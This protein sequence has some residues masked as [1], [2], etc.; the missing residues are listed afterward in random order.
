MLVFTWLAFFALSYGFVKVPKFFVVWL[1]ILVTIIA[2]IGS[3]LQSHKLGH[4]A[5][6]ASG[7]IDYPIYTNAPYRLATVLA[8][9]LVAYIWT[10]FPYPIT[11]RSLLGEKLG[12]L[13]FL[14]A[15]YHDCGHSIA[16]LKMRGKEGDMALKTSPG[17]KLQKVQH[18][19][20]HE[21]M[22]L[23]P[24]LRMH[25]LFQ[26]FEFPIGGRFPAGRYMAIM[27]DMTK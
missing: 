16:S 3:S 22:T 21:I 17:R 9:C 24:A 20:F 23:I 27:Q 14:L 10:L 6:V 12:D 18:R 1:C 15:K 19:L 8:G 4:A 25:A 7:Q 26:K 5:A 11:D 2:I 13:V